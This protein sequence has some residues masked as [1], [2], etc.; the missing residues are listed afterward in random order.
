VASTSMRTA[1][2][3]TTPLTLR[4]QRQGLSLYGPAGQGLAYAAPQVVNRSL[5]LTDAQGVP[6]LSSIFRSRRT[7]MSVV[8]ERARCW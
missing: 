2:T 1:T 4:L 8:T 6:L 7:G 3:D 5:C